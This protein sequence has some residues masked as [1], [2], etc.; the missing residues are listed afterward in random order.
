MVFSD[1]QGEVY[2]NKG[3]YRMYDNVWQK[4]QSTCLLDLSEEGFNVRV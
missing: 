1:W 4:T 3:V 2:Q